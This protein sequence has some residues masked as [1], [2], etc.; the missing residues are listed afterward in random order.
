V[1]TP[2]KPD[3]DASIVEVNPLSFVFAG[4][5]LEARFASAELLPLW[6]ERLALVGPGLLVSWGVRAVFVISWTTRAPADLS[7]VLAAAIEVGLCASALA[8]VAIGRRARALSPIALERLTVSMLGAQFVLV[9]Y[10]VQPAQLVRHANLLLGYA[11][12]TEWGKACGLAAANGP[13]AFGMAAR[14]VVA[15]VVASLLMPLTPRCGISLILFF[16]AVASL[17]A[18]DSSFAALQVLRP[19]TGDGSKTRGYGALQIVGDLVSDV[20]TLGVLA[21]VLAYGFVRRSLAHRH[22]FA[23]RERLRAARDT[24]AAYQERT[25]AKLAKSAAAHAAELRSASAAAQA[26][27]QLIRMVMHDL[28]SPLLSV[29]NISQTL[30]SLSPL[31]KIGVAPVPA[32]VHALSTCSMLMEDI[33]SDMLGARAC[34][35]APAERALPVARS[36]AALRSRP[37]SRPLRSRPQRRARSASGAIAS[38]PFA[39]PRARLRAE[40]VRSPVPTALAPLAGVRSCLSPARSAARTCARPSI[41]P[42]NHPSSIYPS[43]PSPPFRFRA[44]GLGAAHAGGLALRAAAAP[45]HGAR[46]LP[47]RRQRQGRRAARAVARARAR[48]RALPR[49]RAA[50]AAVPQQRHLERAQVHAARRAGRAARQRALCRRA[51]RRVRAL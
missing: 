3:D 6:V 28:R 16:L 20:T 25:E 37:P 50:A 8:L 47:R 5:A 45:R 30:S 34:R 24:H 23:L 11:I 51:L 17:F 22:Q 46:H 1:V 15:P 19:P 12:T 35:S 43:P 14:A 7:S 27:S 32:V 48:R 2:R 9:L 31:H 4:D 18:L 21:M 13:A 10:A 33:V 39:L 40:H 38:F 42:S 26:R 29:S 44:D 49:R 36:C 41:R